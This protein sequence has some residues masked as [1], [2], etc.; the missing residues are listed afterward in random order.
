MTTYVVGDV[1][2]CYDSLILLLKRIEF[3]PENDHIIFAGDIINRGPK[4]L[5]TIRFIKSL[6]DS[7]SLVLGNHDLH[8]IS[9]FYKIRS[10]SSKDTVN[11]LLNAKDAENL[12]NWLRQQPL[13]IYRKDLDLFVSHAGLYPNWSIKQ[14][15]K[16]AKKFS[17]QL[18][19]DNFL[20]LLKRMYGNSPLDYHY[21]LSKYAKLRFTVNSF[22]R[23]RYCQH[24]AT[25]NFSEKHSPNAA[26]R[27]LQPWFKLEN[28][29]NTSTR[30]VFGHWSSL[31]FYNLDNIIC[32]DTGC[33]WGN[34]LTAYNVDKDKFISVKS[35]EKQID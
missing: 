28:K 35:I 6:G 13:A 26:K 14:G 20:K 3:N 5:K 4:S 16:R 32:L 21:H 11:K 22:T 2:G 17:V 29:R 18:K 15:L 30:F 9:V 33:V 7:A 1:Q 31:G 10:A 34:K 19:S 8:L 25:L 12:V 27:G 24:D 23:M